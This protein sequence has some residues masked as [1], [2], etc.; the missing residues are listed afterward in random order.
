MYFLH[1]WIAHSAGMENT[2]N[3]SLQMKKAPHYECPVYETNQYDS[4]VP[5]ILELWRMGS[6][7]S[8]L[9]LPGQPW[10]EMVAPDRVLSMC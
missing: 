7:T 10:F 3:V 6:T 9:S 1:T 4:E 5:L 8:S 2:P